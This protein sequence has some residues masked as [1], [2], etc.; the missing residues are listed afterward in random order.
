MDSIAVIHTSELFLLFHFLS[1]QSRLIHVC[2][3]ISI[4]I[5]SECISQRL[6]HN[7]IIL[8]FSIQYIRNT[9][10][11][12]IRKLIRVRFESVQPASRSISFAL[13]VKDWFRCN[14]FIL[15][16]HQGMISDADSN[17]DID[18]FTPIKQ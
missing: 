6:N 18:R 2:E 12:S 14:Y 9:Y 16:Y 17:S 4:S 1:K 13:V 5:G 3:I 7:L 11:M 8:I 15:R 10:T